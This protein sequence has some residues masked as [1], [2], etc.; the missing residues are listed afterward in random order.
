VAEDER[1]ANIRGVDATV[2]EFEVGAAH[3]HYLR[4][5]DNLAFCRGRLVV[6]DERDAPG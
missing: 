6:L 1:V 4:R 3:P 2:D 5:D